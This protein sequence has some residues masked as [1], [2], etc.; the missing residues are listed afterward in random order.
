MLGGAYILQFWSLSVPCE[1][2]IG[3]GSQVLCAKSMFLFAVRA[4]CGTEQEKPEPCVGFNT[5]K[6]KS[7]FCFLF[8]DPISVG[9]G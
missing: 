7:C 1:A 3:G 6:G 5:T 2:G 9:Q 4:G 8:S